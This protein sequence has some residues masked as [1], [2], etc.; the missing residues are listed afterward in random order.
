LAVPFKQI[1]TGFGKAFNNKGLSKNGQ[2]CVTLRHTAQFAIFA[3]LLTG[4]SLLCK[5]LIN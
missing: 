3:R 1:F 5:F 4:A 2:A